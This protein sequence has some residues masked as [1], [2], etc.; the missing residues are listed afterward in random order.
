MTLDY[1]H[2][3]HGI[4]FSFSSLPHWTFPHSS[5]CLF[6]C[7]LPLPSAPPW[8]SVQLA[9]ILFSVFLL[10]WACSSH[11]TVI[12]QQPLYTTLPR[13]C[14]MALKINLSSSC[15]PQVPQPPGSAM[16]LIPSYSVPPFP[17]SLYSPSPKR[18]L[19]SPGSLSPFTFVP[20]S[21]RSLIHLPRLAL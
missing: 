8:E 1:V 20:D 14:P 5:S 15:G 10:S 4:L 19:E 21:N 16:H 17:G 9:P 7:L 11:S 13:W 18:I 3:D 12:S 2:T 6:L